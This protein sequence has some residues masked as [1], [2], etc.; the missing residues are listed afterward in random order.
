MINI[1]ICASWAIFACTILIVPILRQ[2]ARHTFRTIPEGRSP[3]ASI[4][5]AGIAS[6]I[7]GSAR[8]ARHALVSCG[9][10]M[11]VGGT[12]EAS[13]LRLCPEVRAHAGDTFGAIKVREA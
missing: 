1:I 3:C 12:S 2:K 5:L 11:G 6:Q 8:W 13:L 10:I 9:I 7:E 4:H